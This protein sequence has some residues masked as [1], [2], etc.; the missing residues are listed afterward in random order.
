MNKSQRKFILTCFFA[1][2]ATIGFYTKLM[3]AN[4]Y[5]MF[6]MSVLGIYGAANLIEKVKNQNGNV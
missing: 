5:L 1:V 2:N 3:D 6:A 4:V